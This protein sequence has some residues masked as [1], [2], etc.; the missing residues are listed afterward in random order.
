MQEK[1]EFS[2]NKVSW[3]GQDL[4]NNMSL[5]E[6][7]KA[8]EIMVLT[9]MFDQKAISL[10]RTGKMGTYPSILGQEA[11]STAVGMSLDEADVFVPYYR[12]Q[13]AFLLRGVTLEE[14]MM[15]WGGHEQGNNYKSEACSQ[16]MPVCVPIATQFCHAVGIASAMKLRNEERAV[17]VTGGD[18]ST[19]KG[20]FLESLNLAGV[21][22][23]P[24]VFVVNNNQWAISTPR[25][26]Q[27]ASETIAQKAIGAGV[28]G[29]VVDGNDYVATADAISAALERAKAGKGPTLIEAVSY[30][31][32]DHTTADDAT[33]YRPSEELKEAWEKEPIKRLQKWLFDNG[34]W[35]EDKEKELVDRVKARIDEAVDNYVNTPAEPAT[36]MFDN[37]FAELPK[38]LQKQYDLLAKK[39][40]KGDE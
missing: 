35:S 27:T 39:G 19:S 31:L 18:G 24:V 2:I 21:W 22:H 33:R 29:V 36:S 16:D 37:L 4:P 8:Y 15:Y 30:R 32:S 7:I 23:L 14:I 34:H 9:R 1:I 28:P 13:S 20:D 5:S 12:D 6:V 3:D 17:V 40:G 25:S 38:P 26:V 11:I 10:Q